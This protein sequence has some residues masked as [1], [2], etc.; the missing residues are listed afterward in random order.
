MKRRLLTFALMLC[1]VLAILPQTALALTDTESNDV[2]ASAQKVTPGETIEGMI[3]SKDVDIYTIT[4]GEA[5]RLKLDMT[6]Y[7]QYYTLNLYNAEG[8]ELWHADRMEW[9]SNV[10]YRNDV[11]NFDLEAATYF[12]KVTGFEHGN[13]NPTT[14]TYKL[15]VDF[16]SAEVTETEDNDSIATSDSIAIDGKVNA[17]I[18]LNDSYDF[19]KIALPEDGRLKLDITSHMRFYTMELYNSDGVAIWS[20]DNRE[21]NGNTGHRNDAYYIDLEAAAYYVKITGYTV[22]DDRE[23]RDDAL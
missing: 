15:K 20:V 3:T 4:L 10:G 18:A 22:C 11:F 1:L 13:W 23:A 12:I 2:F 17:Q 21:W 5:G 8:T 14:G 6:A 16:T 9:N 19:F 7:M